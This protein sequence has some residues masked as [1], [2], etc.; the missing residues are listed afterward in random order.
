MI[1]CKVGTLVNAG[2]LTHLVRCIDFSLGSQPVFH[3]ITA[4]EATMFGM[5]IGGNGNLLMMLGCHAIEP[6]VP[7]CL[8]I[9]GSLFMHSFCSVYGMRHM[10]LHSLK[11]S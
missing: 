9:D 6:I 7:G 11:I 1:L 4:F 8:V 3:R 5:E 2:V 10:L